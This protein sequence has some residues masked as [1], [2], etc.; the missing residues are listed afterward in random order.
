[1]KLNKL[2]LSRSV[3]DELA[4]FARWDRGSKHSVLDVH[5]A[6]CNYVRANE[7]RTPEN[8]ALIRLDPTIKSVFKIK[9]DVID[10]FEMSKYIKL[11]WKK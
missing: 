6:V 4:D 5:R 1:M 3:D 8:R 10:F 11:L 9:D 7:L 2:Y